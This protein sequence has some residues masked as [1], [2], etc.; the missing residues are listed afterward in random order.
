V[1]L[2]DTLILIPAGRTTI[3]QDAAV[4]H[5]KEGPVQQVHN[6]RCQRIR[7]LG[8]R[9]EHAITN[10]HAAAGFARRGMRPCCARY[11]LRIRVFGG[12]S[13]NVENILIIFDDLRYF[14]Q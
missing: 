12:D 9:S 5:G 1:I 7:E 8:S 14:A 11:M 6:Q 13:A 4:L 2:D 3:S 10:H